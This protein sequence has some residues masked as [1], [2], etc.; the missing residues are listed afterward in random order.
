MNAKKS[1]YIILFFGAGL[2]IG[3]AW[4]TGSAKFRRTGEQ[5]QLR[6]HVEQV[7]RDLN[8]A[9]GSQWEAAQ[10]ASRL[11]EELQGITEYARS[12]E[13]GTR[14]AEARAGSLAS[15]LDGIINQSGELADGINRASGSIEESR[16]L[17]DELGNI[18]RL[19]PGGIGKENQ[20]P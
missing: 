18:L 16:L 3:Y 2:I 19:I 6:E 7:N 10:L 20:Y 8:A 5:K 11:Q 14:R 9:I 4:G 17:I 15:Q 1:F 13:A 12:L